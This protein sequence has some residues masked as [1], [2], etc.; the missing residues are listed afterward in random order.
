MTTICNQRNLD[1]ESLSLKYYI[2]EGVLYIEPIARDK[3]KSVY[4]VFNL[5]NVSVRCINDS[6]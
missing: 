4:N 1:P 2:Q 6:Y 3:K 5:H